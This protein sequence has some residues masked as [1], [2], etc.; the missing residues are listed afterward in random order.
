MIRY[1]H[2]VCMNHKSI[3]LDILM[4]VIIQSEYF[5]LLNNY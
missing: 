1:I 5:V 2:I 4:S 3:Y